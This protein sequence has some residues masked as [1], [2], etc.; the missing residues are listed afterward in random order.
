M[1]ELKQRLL[2]D[3]PAHVEHVRWCLQDTE[4]NELSKQVQ[5][6]IIFIVAAKNKNTSSFLEMH[7]SDATLLSFVVESKTDYDLLYKHVREKF[8]IPINIIALSQPMFALPDDMIM[9][10]ITDNVTVQQPILLALHA[11]Y[12][13]TIDR[14]FD[15]VAESYGWVGIADYRTFNNDDD[16]E[17]SMRKFVNHM[18]IMNCLLT[19]ISI[20]RIDYLTMTT[21]N[22][23]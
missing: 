4:Q 11:L 10:S 13:E 12:E 9:W 22:I 16:P 20:A 19:P 8:G 21:I 1:D 14:T 23:M 2:Q 3:H 18:N 15:N 17:V 6:P 7:F 5:G